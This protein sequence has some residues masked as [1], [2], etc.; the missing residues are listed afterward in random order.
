MTGRAIHFRRAALDLA[1]VAMLAAQ[2]DEDDSGTVGEARDS[3]S[4]ETAARVETPVSRLAKQALQPIM[5][6]AMCCGMQ[7]W[8]CVGGER[9]ARESSI[10]LQ[11]DIIRSSRTG[12]A[13]GP[14][15]HTKPSSEGPAATRLPRLPETVLLGCTNAVSIA[16]GAT[17]FRKAAT[18][19]R[20]THRNKNADDYAKQT[21]TGSIAMLAGGIEPFDAT[22]AL[23]VVHGAPERPV[24][25]GDRGDR[26]PARVPAFALDH[27]AALSVAMDTV[28]RGQRGE[29][30]HRMANTG[31]AASVA[32]KEAGHVLR[33]G[34]PPCHPCG[35]HQLRMQSAIPALVQAPK[36]ASPAELL[37]EMLVPVEVRQAASSGWQSGVRNSL[38]AAAACVPAVR[39]MT[40]PSP[41]LPMLCRRE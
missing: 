27:A 29:R 3:A 18:E 20:R 28:S 38:K 32:V 7:L 26:F 1:S 23:P 31:R 8:D 15:L 11:A 9:L 19:F 4:D 22:A 10:R 30:K 40:K 24:Y 12:V 21:C 2:L 35:L 33:K 37:W 36:D 17:A 13:F 14:M 34:Q 16:R 41:G 25:D 5:D 39:Q 6:L